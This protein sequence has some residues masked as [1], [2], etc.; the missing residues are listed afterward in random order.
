[1]KVLAA[2]PDVWST[3]RCTYSADATFQTDEAF[4][5][6]MSIAEALQ[7]LH[8][9]KV[10]HGDVYAH[11]I[12]HDPDSRA[13]ILGDFGAAWYYGNLAGELHAKIERVEVRAYGILL[14]EL[15]ARVRD[16]REGPQLL[17]QLAGD[18]LGPTVGQ[19]PAFAEVVRRLRARGGGSV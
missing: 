2:P 1:M 14:Q 11:N 6:A 5:I 12:L 13:T 7:D 17:G 15:A 9:A 4:Q 16:G 10:C 18:C 19:R 3:L 8:S